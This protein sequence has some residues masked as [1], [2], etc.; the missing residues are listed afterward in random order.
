MEKSLY[1]TPTAIRS[2]LSHQVGTRKR[3]SCSKPRTTARTRRILEDVDGVLVDAESLAP[4]RRDPCVVDTDTLAALVGAFTSTWTAGAS[5]AITWLASRSSVSEKTIE[6]IVSRR[7]LTTELRIA[8]PI[9]AACGRPDLIHDGTIPVR[10][11]PRLSERAR[12][13]CCGSRPNETF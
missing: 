4:R 13:A 7:T 8:D 5:N 6:N 2:T 9:V 1:A 10:P 12:A 11:N 3:I